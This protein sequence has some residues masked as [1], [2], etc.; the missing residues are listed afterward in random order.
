MHCQ[1]IPDR[2]RLSI[3]LR[4][5][6]E[7]D[8]AVASPLA[9]ET[10]LGC[11]GQG[12]VRDVLVSVAQSMDNPLALVEARETQRQDLLLNRRKLSPKQHAWLDILYDRERRRQG[13]GHT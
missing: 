9:P 3:Q 1:P 2:F 8:G 10:I 6:P 5:R 13:H 4:K 7:A 11:R 12:T